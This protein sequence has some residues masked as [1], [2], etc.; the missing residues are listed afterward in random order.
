MHN[1]K[2]YSNSPCKNFD[3]VQDIKDYLGK[4]KWAEISPQM[5]HIKDKEQFEMY[6]SVAGISGFPVR[7]WYE[8]YHGQGSW[9]MTAAEAIKLLQNLSGDPEIIDSEAASVLCNFLICLGHQSVV[10]AFN[11]ATKWEQP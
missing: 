1:N 5:A 10:D 8:L 4:K 9:N 2:D 11:V 6:C 3:A 7:A